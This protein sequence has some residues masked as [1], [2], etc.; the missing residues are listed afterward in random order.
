MKVFS[1]RLYKSPVQ[2]LIPFACR[3]LPLQAGK[4]LHYFFHYKI[5]AFT[6][7]PYKIQKYITFFLIVFFCRHQF[8]S[9]RILLAVHELYH[10]L[11]ENTWVKPILKPGFF[12]LSE[13]SISY[14]GNTQVYTASS[15]L[16]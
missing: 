14:G 6:Y 4:S 16:K 8:T 15:F 3:N 11:P 7:G 9:V 2:F 10:S 13:T 5:N 12:K 1:C